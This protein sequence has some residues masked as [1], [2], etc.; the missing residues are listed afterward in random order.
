MSPRKDPSP[1][2]LWL[3]AR[4]NEIGRARYAD[5]W[6]PVTPRRVER[7]SEHDGL[8]IEPDRPGLG[9]R[10]GRRADY[11][12]VHAQRLAD[13][14]ARVRRG[15]GLHR[16]VLWLFADGIDVDGD[17]IR[18][19]Y[20]QQL[21]DLEQHL[22]QAATRAV[23]QLGPLAL[24]PSDLDP[25]DLADLLEPELARHLRS[26][27]GDGK[28]KRQASAQIVAQTLVGAQIDADTLGKVAQDLGLPPE[29]VTS[30][31]AAGDV[32]RRM[33][34]VDLDDLRH[35]AE[36]ATLEELH[37]YLSVARQLGGELLE[38]VNK[39]A[40]EL[41]GTR[42]LRIIS[43]PISGVRIALDALSIGALERRLS[44]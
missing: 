18:R 22:S 11:G 30:P 9:Q 19:A 38:V 26:I 28:T 10:K 29:V 27:H 14:A 20:L 33:E 6:D 31:G 41:R 15:Q 42:A 1:G 7:W 21:D 37:E 25:A 24:P 40:P 39:Y 32:A 43:A 17:V 4:A 16:T 34:T 23:K 2:M 12:E 5:R 44:R 13:V 36:Q 35:V 8:L 3:C